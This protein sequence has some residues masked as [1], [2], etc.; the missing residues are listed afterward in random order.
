MTEGMRTWVEVIFNIVYLIL[1]WWLVVA[2]YKQQG[3]LAPENRQVGRLFM[4]AFGLLAL[5]DTGHV[6]LRVLAYALGGLEKN[7]LLIGAG[8]FMTS[9]TVTIFYVIML[10]IWRVVWLVYYTH[11]HSSLGYLAAPG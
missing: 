2:M 3:V 11:G 9:I 10:F 5:G 1:V 4:W 6:G 8:A 7:A